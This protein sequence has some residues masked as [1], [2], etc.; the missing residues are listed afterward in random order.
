LRYIQTISK[1]EHHMQ[2]KE[3]ADAIAKRFKAPASW[4]DIREVCDQATDGELD[5]MQLD[6]L[7]D[8]VETRLKKIA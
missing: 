1:G 6:L 5:A 2:L 4:E 7:T 8:M 3:K